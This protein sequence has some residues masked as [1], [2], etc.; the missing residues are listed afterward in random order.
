MTQDELRLQ[1]MELVTANT[2]GSGMRRASL[3]RANR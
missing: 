1:I 3:L 2:P